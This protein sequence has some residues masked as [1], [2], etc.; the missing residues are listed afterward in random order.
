MSL[1]GLPFITAGFWSKDEI[2]AEA[3]YVWSH[4]ANPL[5]IFV[6][7]MLALS[8]FLTAFYTMR[9][10]SLTFLGAPRSPLAEHAHESNNFMTFPLL[11]LSVFAV[12]A[13]W[14][15]IPDNFLG[16]GKAFGELLPRI[17]WRYYP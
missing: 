11:V 7:V 3:W 16:T 17:H 10:I 14:F 6:L 9:Q 13:G 15:G 2:F 12:I 5:G 8:A 4:D 1:A